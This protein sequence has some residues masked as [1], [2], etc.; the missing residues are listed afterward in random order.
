[1]KM[2]SDGIMLKCL[3]S[4]NINRFAF[5]YQKMNLY[6]EKTLLIQ[7]KNDTILLN[8]RHEYL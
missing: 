5:L 2:N 7:L 6:I 4:Q 8:F 3:K 1:M